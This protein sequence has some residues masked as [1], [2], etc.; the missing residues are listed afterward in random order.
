MIES[1]WGAERKVGVEVTYEDDSI[2]GLKEYGYGFWS[3]F[4]WNG[5]EKLINKPAWMALS[6]LSINENYGD[7]S[8]IGDRCL[9]I[10][11]GTPFYH[12]T[13]STPGNANVWTNVNYET[14]LDG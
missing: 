5:P 3:R 7:A 6:R 1:V 14:M 8:A 2:N 11:V 13:T 10:W 12:F 4:A 9:A